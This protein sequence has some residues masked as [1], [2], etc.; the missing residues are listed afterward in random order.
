[1]GDRY[2]LATVVPWNDTKDWSGDINTVDGVIHEVSL[3][4]RKHQGQQF[5]EK[6]R[7]QPFGNDRPLPETLDAAH[8]DLVQGPFGEIVVVRA[9]LDNVEWWV[10]K[11]RDTDPVANLPEANVHI[12]YLYNW[13]NGR[14]YAGLE[15][16]GTC[17][18]R[19][20]DGTTEWSQHSP[21]QAPDPGCNAIDWHSTYQVMYDL[22]RDVARNRNHC[23]KILFYGHEWTP[24]TG[25]IS[26]PSIGH[27]HD[28]HVHM[29]GPIDHGPLAG[30]CNY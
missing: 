27:S 21:W 28:D 12:D 30:A 13:V 15:N 16:W 1:M 8:H 6:R 24:G 22:S 25:W 4:A 23:A 5:D 18:R 29:E 20:I 2:R 3:R 26:A 17:N 19:F 14:H 10:R 11:L 7:G 9:H